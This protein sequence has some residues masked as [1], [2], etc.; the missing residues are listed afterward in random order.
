MEVEHAERIEVVWRRLQREEAKATRRRRGLSDYALWGLG[1]AAVAGAVIVAGPLIAPLMPAAAG[2]SG[3]AAFSA[4]MA[5]LGF[6]SIAA[7]GPGMTGGMWMLGVAGGVVGFGSAAGIQTALHE[8]VGTP[9]ASGL[10][11]IEVVKL[12]TSATLA[13]QFGWFGG[14]L[15]P[16]KAAID[17]IDTEVDET[18]AAEQSRNDPNA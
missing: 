15:E 2:L 4:G 18:L 14:D 10:L 16:F 8:A 12:L 7:G 13:K 1:A 11:R 9:G 3:A 5:Q 6:G 17:R